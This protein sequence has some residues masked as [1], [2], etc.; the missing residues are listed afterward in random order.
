M[1]DSGTLSSDPANHNSQT[2][3]INDHGQVAGSSE[4]DSM[5]SHAFIYEDGK[6]SDLGTLP[7]H[8]NSGAFGINNRGQVVGDSY[9]PLDHPFL[10]D[11]GVMINLAAGSALSSLATAINNRGDAVGYAR[12]SDH[13]PFAP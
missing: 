11:K 1:T 2:S 10:F 4:T 13:A 8:V 6:M 12:S 9:S 5:Q 3:A 7:G